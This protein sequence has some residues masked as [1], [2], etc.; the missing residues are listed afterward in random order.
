MELSDLYQNKIFKDLPPREL[1]KRHIPVMEHRLAPSSVVVEQGETGRGLCLIGSGSIGISRKQANGCSRAQEV[2]GSGDFFGVMGFL[3]G[4]PQPA[5]AT[6]G[7]D[8][9]V[10]WEIS[11]GGLDG[12]LAASLEFRARFQQCMNERLLYWSRQFFDEVEDARRLCVIGLNLGAVVH[13]LKT[14]VASIMQTAYYLRHCAVPELTRLGE[15]AESSARRME[16]LT[17]DILDYS[18]GMIQLKLDP[19]HVETLLD[20]LD[21][22]LKGHP[23]ADENQVHRSVESNSLLSVDTGKILRVFVNIA[24]NAFEAMPQGG[25]LSIIVTKSDKDIL[26][27]FKDT[28]TG[29]PPAALERIFEPFFTNGKTRGTGLGMA[30]AKNLIE[31]H[32]GRIWLQSRPEPGTS[33]FI[34]I[35]LQPSFSDESHDGTALQL[36]KRKRSPKRHER[37]DL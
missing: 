12:Y 8:P 19:V 15:A 10:V 30:I 18:S 22:E 26:F 27:E 9:A 29:V 37:L 21:H 24:V 7:N 16:Q 28:G 2:H 25:S 17:Q 11:P 31:A 14:P 6:V 5:R 13:D 33:V 4:R 1:A 23:F 3:D 35:P 34:L 36:D 20:Q 32:Q